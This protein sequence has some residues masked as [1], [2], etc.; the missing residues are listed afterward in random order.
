MKLARLVLLP[1]ICAL[2]IL[3]V[4]GAQ[5]QTVK[6]L[7]DGQVSKTAP[8]WADPPIKSSPTPCASLAP[9]PAAECETPHRLPR[10]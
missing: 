6:K 7:S 10:A 3:P 2:L 9:K 1:S 5:A 8:N 4:A